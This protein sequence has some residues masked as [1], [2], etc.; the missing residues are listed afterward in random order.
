MRLSRGCGVLLHISSLPGPF[1]GGTLGGSAREMADRLAAAGVSYWQ[2]LPLGPVCGHLGYS[3][4]SSP[5]AF[6]GN[7]LFLNPEDLAERG[8][9]DRQAVRDAQ[10]PEN[11][12]VDWDE[13]VR[14]R[15]PLLRAAAGAFF[16]APNAGDAS[17][18]AAFCR[19]QRPW[20][21]DYALFSALA[22]H[23]GTHDW[24]S[25]PAPIVRR[26]PAALLEWS[27]RLAK[28]VAYHRFGQ[29]AF[30]EQWHTFARHCQRLGLQLVGDI[31]FYVNFESADAWSQPSVFLLDEATGRPAVVAGVPP[32]YF[33]ATGQRW[34]NPIYRWHD[35]AGQLRDDTVEWWG[36]RLAHLLGL[37][38]RVRIDHF[39]GFSA[40]WEIPAAEPS[41]AGGRWIPGPGKALFDR[42]AVRLGPLPLIAEDLG[43]VTPDV[44]RLRDE[45]DLPG[46]KVLQFAFDRD[47]GNAYLPQNYPTPHCLVYTGTHDNNTTNGWFYG[48]EAGEEIR[49]HITEYLGLTHR[50]EFHWQLIRLGMLSTADICMIPMQDLL[51]FGAEFRMNQPGQAGGNWRWKLNSGQPS[52]AV[53]SRLRQQC[54]LATR[55][56]APGVAEP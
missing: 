32:D 8:W 49:G 9:L 27:E 35:S 5:S 44:V 37:T 40:H 11:D 34:G 28:D 54:Q 36:R 22:G 16:S 41:A 56:P 33:S 23:F 50:D 43:L 31:P 2:V 53:L 12:F 17:R 13:L 10:L 19:S 20:L 51:G 26:D 45:L 29:F 21:D 14:R 7:P 55:L 18:F 39:R 30:F 52:P 1:G 3:P 48:P 4:Y 46:M 15:T 38:P 42:L 47:P 25:W 6:A 24:P